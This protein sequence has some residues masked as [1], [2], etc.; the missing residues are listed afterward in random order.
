M[1]G[2]CCFS[3]RVCMFLVLRRF[4]CLTMVS[5]RSRGGEVRGF[6]LRQNLLIPASVRAVDRVRRLVLDKPWCRCAPRM[7]IARFG[8]VR[9]H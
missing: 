9:A 3:E 6:G 2:G 5:L 4:F 8:C 1:S 7:E